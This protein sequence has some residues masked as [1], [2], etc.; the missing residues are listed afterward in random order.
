MNWQPAMTPRQLCQRADIVQQVR[1]F[2]I[3]RDVL[4]VDTP[5]LMPTPVTDPYLETFSVSVM[6]DAGRKQRYLQ[7][8]PEYAM[9]RL[10]AGG[11]GSIFQLCKAFRDDE[12]GRMHRAEFT[13]LE[14]YRIGFD[15]HQLMSEV[16][17][18]LCELLQCNR[19]DQY[20][21]QDVFM[22]VL[23]VDPH[24]I[25]TDQLRYLAKQHCH[26]CVQATLNRDDYLQ[27][28]FQHVIEPTLG[29]HAPAIVYDFPASQAALARLKRVNGV[30]VAARFE[31]YFQGV[32][33]ANGYWELTD[34]TVQRQRFEQD[35]IRRQELGVSSVPIDTRLLGALEHGLPDC[36]GVAL[37][38]DRLLMLAMGANNINE[39]NT[40]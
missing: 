19:A 28:L 12:L 13:M 9:K 38:F 40:F 14:W 30:E 7:T 2:F 6:T 20:S 37:G 39:V 5:L 36:A 8:S 22:Q 34:P 15:D 23:G 17:D 11:S 29:K 24:Q 1:Q 18:L 27:L 35:L 4:E 16:S 26:L 33:L 25:G 32:E 10:L 3:V 21:Y 31:V